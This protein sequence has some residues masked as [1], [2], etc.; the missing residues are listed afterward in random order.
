MAGRTEDPIDLW[1]VER[2]VPHLIAHYRARTD[3]WSRAWPILVVAYV[4]GGFLALDIHGW[5]LA[6]NLLATVVIV[7]VLAAMVVI[8]NAVAHRPLFGRPRSSV[9]RSWRRSCSVR[10]SRR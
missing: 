1:F 8:T 5:S 6:R 10:R 2:G 4:A 3:V 9:H 7:A